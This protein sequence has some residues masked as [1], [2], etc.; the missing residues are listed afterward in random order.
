M[1]KMLQQQWSGN[2]FDQMSAE[3]FVKS[4]AKQILNL[5]RN[6]QQ[7]LAMRNASKKVALKEAAGNAVRKSAMQD[8]VKSASNRA[9][10]KESQNLGMGAETSYL[11]GDPPFK[12]VDDGVTHFNRSIGISFHP[13]DT[14]RKRSK[15]YNFSQEQG[16]VEKVENNIMVVRW[17]SGKKSKYSLSSPSKIFAELEKV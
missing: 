1:D 16:V 10:V 8:A 17:Q 15:G 4:Q 6:Q 14:V 7:E 13:G 2:V 5:W 3:N 9:R 12:N 11:E